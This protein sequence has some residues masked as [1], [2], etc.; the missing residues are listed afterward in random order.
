[1]MREAQEIAEKLGR[2][3]MH[4]Y[5]TEFGFGAATG[6]GGEPL[7]IGESTG[8][9]REIDDWWGVTLATVA[10][11]QGLTVTPVQLAGAYN[12]I[13]NG[14]EYVSPSIVSG[15]RTGDGEMMGGPPTERR[16]VLS[17]QTAGQVSLML[18]EVVAGE[19]GTGSRAAVPGYLVAGKTGT[20]QKVNADGEY[21][22]TAYMATFAGFVPADDPE[23]TIVIV[24][25]EPTTEHLAG[26]VAAPLFSELAR[27][28]LGSLR[29]S[30]S[31]DLVAGEPTA[32]ASENVLSGATD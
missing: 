6:P 32:S 27:S 8:V 13:A 3:K 4:G 9:V 1:M 20:A 15:Y 18:Q 2:T 26:L 25:D 23:L 29:I 14:G 7:L 10:F 12:T 21:S 24:V 28:T 17:E 30:P 22:E 5:L 16:R 11:G 19:R 31:A